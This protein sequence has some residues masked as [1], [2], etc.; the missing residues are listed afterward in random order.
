MSAV[1]SR[2]R[3]I[4]LIASSVSGSDPL[5]AMI[6]LPTWLAIARIVRSIEV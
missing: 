6:T 3:S 1:C 2:Q 4:A 5:S